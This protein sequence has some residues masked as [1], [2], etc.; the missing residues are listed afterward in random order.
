MSIYAIVFAVLCCGLFVAAVVFVGIGLFGREVCPVYGDLSP[1]GPLPSILVRKGRD[2]KGGYTPPA[3]E[4]GERND[5]R[6][7]R[8]KEG[9]LPPP[10]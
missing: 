5:V 7:I 1:P 4:P 9:E 10:S 8:I 6:V 2:S 3:V